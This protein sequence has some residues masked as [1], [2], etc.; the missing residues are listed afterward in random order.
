MSEVKRQLKI[1]TGSVRRLAKEVVMYKKDEQTETDR[2]SRMKAAGGDPSDIKHA[3]QV[4]A[5]AAMMVPDTRQ[6]LETA[7]ADLQQCLSQS[8][9]VQESEEHQ[10]AKQTA[11]EAEAVLA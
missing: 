5:E 11:S 8:S 7:L 1:K 6:R 10:Q 2:V 4:L 3:E 9:K